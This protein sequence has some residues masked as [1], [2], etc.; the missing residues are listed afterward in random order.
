M[1]IMSLKEDFQNIIIPGPSSLGAWKWFRLTGVLIHQ[2]CG[3]FF[4]APENWKV[5][6]GKSCLPFCWHSWFF[7]KYTFINK[8]LEKN[9]GLALT[10]FL[11]G[12]MIS[13]R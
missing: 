13:R 1:I 11:T 5:T 2:P 12:R 8:Q 6:A 10:Q 7:L 4:P 3:W 9:A